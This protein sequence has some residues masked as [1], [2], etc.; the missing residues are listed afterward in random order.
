MTK[1]DKDYF[2]INLQRLLMLLLKAIVTYWCWRSWRPFNRAIQWSQMTNS[3]WPLTDH[4]F[5]H[6]ISNTFFFFFFSPALVLLKFFMNWSSNIAWVLLN[7]YISI[8]NLWH[9][10]YLLYLCPYLDLESVYMRWDIP[11]KWDPSSMMNF[12]LYKQIVYMRMNSS[13]PHEIS[14]QCWWDLM[15]MGWILSLL[16]VFPGLSHLGKIVIWF[17]LMF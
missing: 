11:P 17:S 7:I 15:E 6:C 16:T 14:P 13:Q 2:K 12:T 9:F 5:K 8:I 3:Q 10:L 1:Y 4:Y